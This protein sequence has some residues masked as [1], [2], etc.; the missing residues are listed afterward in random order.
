MKESLKTMNTFKESRGV[1]LIELMVALVISAV[2]I[3]ALYRT[4]IGQQKTYTVQEQVVDMQQNARVAVSRLIR[5]VR[6]AGFGNV[7][8]VLPSMGQSNAFTMNGDNITVIGAYRQLRDAATNEPITIASTDG[9]KTIYLSHPTDEFNNYDYIC[10]GGLFSYIVQ[11]TKPRGTEPTDKLT[12]DRRIQNPMGAYVYKIESITYNI[13]NIADIADSI[14]NV[15]FQYLDENGN[16][17]GTAANVRMIR[18]AVTAKTKDADPD[19]KGV[20]GYRRR[21]ITSNIQMRNI[22]IGFSP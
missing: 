6:L 11:G 3:A 17:T 7:G 14:E 1:T 20:G 8:S 16:P 5:N 21:V 18:L 12:L 22:G 10:I 19:Y 2:L 4:F 9:D 15:Q 13:S